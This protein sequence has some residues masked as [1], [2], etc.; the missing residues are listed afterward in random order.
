MVILAHHELFVVRMARIELSIVILAQQKKWMH[1][2]L[3]T[4]AMLRKVITRQW[5]TGERRWVWLK[6]SHKMSEHEIK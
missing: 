5:R 6:E 3:Q 4:V 1:G 2:H